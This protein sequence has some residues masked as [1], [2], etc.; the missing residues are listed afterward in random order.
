MYSQ[1]LKSVLQHAVRE[2]G[3]TVS[4]T[5]ENTLVSLASAEGMPGKN[6]RLSVFLILCFLD[7][8]FLLSALAPLLLKRLNKAQAASGQLHI[9]S[10]YPEVNRARLTIHPLVPPREPSLKHAFAYV[11]APHQN[12]VGMPCI[13]G[14]PVIERRNFGPPALQEPAKMVSFSMQQT[15]DVH[16]IVIAPTCLDQLFD[17]EAFRQFALITTDHSHEVHISSVRALYLT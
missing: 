15:R 7:A 12:D 1:R 3:L 5:D 6:R 11:V 8:L 13:A 2:L 9:A 10:A 4:L 16:P 14:G 17:F